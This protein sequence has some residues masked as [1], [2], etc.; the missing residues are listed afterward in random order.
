MN[1][2]KIANCAYFFMLNLVR[3][4]KLVDHWLSNVK[5]VLNLQIKVRYQEMYFRNNENDEV[6]TLN[7]YLYKPIMRIIIIWIMRKYTIF[8]KFIY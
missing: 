2:D 8:Q 4:K 3:E 5:S 7:V 6:N 1:G